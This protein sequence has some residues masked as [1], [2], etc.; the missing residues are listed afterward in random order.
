MPLEANTPDNVE[1]A[2]Q[3]CE[4][5]PTASYEKAL[6]IY[7]LVLNDPHLDDYVISEMGR[8]DRYFRFT[9]I[10]RR[11]DGF[12]HWLYERCRE[13]E[14][15]TD[16]CLDLWARGHYKSSFI[17]F[18]GSFQEMIKDSEITIGIFSHNRPIA[19]AFL[20]QIKVE[21]ET[22]D[23]LFRYYP[24]VFWKNPKKDSPS[25]SLDSGI[26]MIRKTNPKEKTIE[27][28]GLVDSQPVSKHFD[29][30]IYNDVVTMDSVA[31]PEMILKT[32]ERWELS[33]N[34][35]KTEFVEGEKPGRQWHE[36][37]RYSFGDTYGIL[38]TRKALK[39]RLYP[40]TDNG[41]PDGNPV[42]LTETAWERKKQAESPRTIA[43]QQLQNPLAGEEQEFKESWIRRWEVR[44]E[45]LNVAIL[46]DPASSKKKGTSNTAMPVIGVGHGLNKYLLDGACHKMSLTERWV[47]LKSLRNKWL[48]QPGVQT[49]TIG[50]EKYGMQA[51][52][53]H[54]HE[55]MELEEESF[56][57]QELNWP[58]DDT[59]AKDDRIRRLIPDHQNWRFF[60][61]WERDSSK[62][63]E[64][65][66]ARMRKADEQK[67]GYLCAKPIKRRNQDGHIYNLVDWFIANEYMF[68]PATTSKDFLDA[69]S[70]IYDLEIS[71]PIIYSEE[72]LLPPEELFGT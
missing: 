12:H 65:D 47:M 60:Y 72:D 31:T 42:F 70:R 29:L 30:R 59:N 61:P 64:V 54:F 34:L 68:F 10:L 25:W 45:T 43:T 3:V 26:T 32:T 28:W 49:V 40:A 67:K 48:N 38:L 11:G 17:T 21:C 27:A 63:N 5:L 6:E 46:V 8:Y 53:E 71:A 9:M 52:I 1:Y 4:F 41:L 57:I 62:P 55:M 50:Y 66:T 24:D 37:T 19:K 22:N 2:R 16:D 51:D 56:P 20:D 7:Q 33:Q 36:G 44:P 18:A 39:P 14:A 35:A 13:V 58:R 15:E 23:N 69:M